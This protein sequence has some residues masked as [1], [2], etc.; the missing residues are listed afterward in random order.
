MIAF[1][2]HDLFIRHL[3]GYG[4]IER[5]DRLAAILERVQTGSLAGRLTMVEPGPADRESICLVHDPK[6]V[7]DILSLTVKDVVV[8]DW[9]DTAATP[10][11]PKAALY[12]AGAC[13]QAARAVMKGE[14]RSAFC[15]VRPPGHHAERDRAMGFC[16]F[17]NI[18]IA[19]AD[20]LATQGVQRVAIVDW[21]VHHG[22]GT[23]KTFLEENRVLFI[24]VHQ[25]PHYPGSGDAAV[26]GRGKGDGYTLNIPLG[27]G[28]GDADFRAAFEHKV[29]PALNA[30]QPEIILISAGFDAHADDPLSETCA[31]SGLFGELTRKV[32]ACAETHCSGRIVSVL[33]GGYDL[34]ALADSVEYHLLALAD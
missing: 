1:Y 29:I 4:H 32:K 28:A 13:V 20:L 12:A 17:N 22:N 24:S 27:A 30:F 10:A 25:F 26:T 3:E 2:T 23:E 16:I 21:D 7:D 19:A 5:P 31:S 34:A 11:S 18:A 6:Y 15:A 8:L 33:E 9:G 14:Y